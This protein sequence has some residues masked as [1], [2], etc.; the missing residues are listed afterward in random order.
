MTFLIALLC[1]TAADVDGWANWRGP[2]DDGMA[3]GDAPLE[4]SDTKNIAWKLKIPGRG[5]S[6]PIVWGDRI[7]V[8]SAVAGEAE[9]V[10]EAPPQ[11]GRRGGMRSG[12]ARG[13]DHKFLLYCIDRKTGKILWERIANTAPPHEGY[14]NRYGS[15]ASNTPATDGKIVYA[16]FG[17]FGLYAYDFDGKQL[18]KVRALLVV[19]DNFA[20]DAERESERLCVDT[21]Q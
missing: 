13:V 1:V 15:Y 19:D 16:F 8:T 20:A 6:S 14:H 7:F 5:F 4:W 21:V 17:S 2:K 9:P 18:W 11:Q 10:V 3:R 12:G